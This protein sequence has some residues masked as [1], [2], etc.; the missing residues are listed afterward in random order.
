MAVGA[1]TDSAALNPLRAPPSAERP[2]T[3]HSLL[4]YGRLSHGRRTFKA[5]CRDGGI[6]EQLTAAAWFHCVRSARVPTS[7]SAT[8]LLAA[9]LTV[10]KP[11]TTDPL[12]LPPVSGA[13]LDP[14]I[15]KQL[16]EASYLS[17]PKNADRYRTITYYFHERYKL[18]QHRL[19]PR[20]VHDYV[21]SVY[22]QTYTLEACVRDLEQLRE[23]KN[24]DR[25]QDREAVGSIEEWHNRDH[26]YDLTPWTVRFERML[27][28]ARHDTGTR[29]SLDPTLIEVIRASVDGLHRTIERV[30][31]AQGTDEGFIGKNIRLPWETIYSQFEKLTESTNDFHHALREA[32]TED[33]ADTEAFL[34]YKD[35]LLDNLAG[36]VNELID[37]GEHLRYYTREWQAGGLGTRL[38][39]LLAR[40][41]AVT[42]LPTS[43]Q[44]AVRTEYERQVIAFIAWFQPGGG[45]DALKRTTRT[46]IQTVVHLTARRVERNRIGGSRREQLRQ[47]AAAFASCESLPDAHLLAALTLGSPGAR[48]VQGAESWGMLNDGRSIWEQPATEIPMRRIVRGRRPTPRPQPVANRAAEQQALLQEEERKRQREQQRWDALFATGPIVFVDLELPDID[49]R[50]RILDALDSCLT[51]PD[52]RGSGSDGSALRLV[53]PAAGT[54]AGVIR[55][56]DGDLHLPRFTL[57]RERSGEAVI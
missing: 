16:I 37:A 17:A 3:T 34:L 5:H 14:T 24:L 26:V 54:P 32:Y 35:V 46:A 48:H 52:G 10:T 28:E 45:I 23:W 22:D 49:L 27:E 30:T 9:L 21:R 55:A 31:P 33:L 39:N 25:E 29:G 53:E 7:V 36:F 20:E 40:S 57:V 1:E 2:T 47:L 51:S 42:T 41:K 6:T 11:T 43:E 44:P 12:R 38:I 18:Q 4:A 15:P 8:Q 56:P 13:A 19:K 50:D